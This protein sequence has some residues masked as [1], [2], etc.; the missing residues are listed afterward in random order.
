MSQFAKKLDFSLSSPAFKESIQSSPPFIPA[1]LPSHPYI[2]SSKKEASSKKAKLLSGFHENRDGGILIGC[3]EATSHHL[4]CLAVMAT[5]K[6][7]SSSPGTKLLGIARPS[8]QDCHRK[9]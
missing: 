9:N 7:S 2:D 5:N 3:D 4:S 6:S 8:K 1:A